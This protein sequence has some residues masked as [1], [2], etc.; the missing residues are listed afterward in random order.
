[1]VGNVEATA[2]VRVAEIRQAT[3]Q[4]FTMQKC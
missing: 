3:N 4:K 1:M 2:N